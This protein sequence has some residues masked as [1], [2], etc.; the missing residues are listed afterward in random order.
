M[1]KTARVGVSTE[2]AS[3]Q[4]GGHEEQKR[5]VAICRITFPKRGKE[6]NRFASLAGQRASTLVHTAQHGSMAH[7]ISTSVVFLAAFLF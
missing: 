2:G 6:H 1:Q 3:K 7:R 5:H 4:T